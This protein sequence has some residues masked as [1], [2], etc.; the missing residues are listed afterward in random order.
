MLSRRKWN[1]S[2]RKVFLN[3]FCRS[4]RGIIYTERLRFLQGLCEQS[5]PTC[6]GIIFH[7]GP[8]V[9]KQIFWRAWS[10]TAL[11]QLKDRAL[12][13]F[14]LHALFGTRWV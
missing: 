4:W 9:P 14:L 8:V 1:Y 10:L 2:G 13:F 6:S 12:M 7:G 11:P 3:S 5:V